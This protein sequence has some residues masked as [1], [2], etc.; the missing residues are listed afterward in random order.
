[1]TRLRRIGLTGGIATGKSTVAE[2]L[3]EQY[4]IPVLDA[5]AF[6]RQVLAPGSPASLAVLHR[7]GDGVR[8]SVDPLSLDRPALARIVFNSE[9]ERRWLEHLVHPE[10]RLHFN[11]A[12]EALAEE[13]VVVLMI[14]LLFEAGLEPL[15]SE[16]WVVECGSEAEQVRR[17]QARDGLTREEA[18][19]RLRAQWPMP[20]KQALADVVISNRGPRSTLLAQV[21]DALAAPPPAK[22][23]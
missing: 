5:D 13:P 1:M 8:S 2:L 22:K 10:V 17:L 3:A 9:E 12:L 4:G 16:I 7:Y 11:T 15:C 21:A 14:P 23:V 20:A 19:A 6:A 18:Q